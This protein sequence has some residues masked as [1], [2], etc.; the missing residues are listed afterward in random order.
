MFTIGLD[1]ASQQDYTALS[2]LR[3]DGTTA[4]RTH[5]CG[6][7]RRWQKPY[8]ETVS[9]VAAVAKRPAFR[10]APIVA[11]QTGVGRPVV[12]MLRDALPG[13]RVIGVTITAGSGWSRGEHK[14]DVRISK[15]LLC[16]TLQVLLAERRLTFSGEL[17]LAPVLES[18]L[19]N[20]RVKITP[21]LNEQYEAWRERDH[22]DLVL[23]LGLAAFVAENVPKPL[24]DEQVRNL[25]FLPE[26]ASASAR[27]GKS[28][29][30]GE[31]VKTRADALAEEFPELF[32][33]G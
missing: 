13:R 25:V 15:K 18:E 2:V 28:A 26:P 17:E 7:L 12:D 16:S 3:T 21:S 4:G 32:G 5:F 20:F 8:P 24:T 27:D 14:D 22:D 9:L 19:A 1:L 10:G 23:S 6:A 33:A 30:A 31:Y 29:A 11:D